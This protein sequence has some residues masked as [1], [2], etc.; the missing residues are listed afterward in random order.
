M[1]PS[2]AP[3]QY[4]ERSRW[5]ARPSGGRATARG[6]AMEREASKSESDNASTSFVGWVSDLAR[7]HTTALAR[8]ARSEG[9]TAD[10]A[11][12]AVQEA[13]QTFLGLPQARTLV[14]D[15]DDSRALLSVVV[16]NA[17][18]NLRRRHHRARPHVALDE[19]VERAEESPSVEDLLVRAE[20]H[21]RLLGC[22]SRLGDVQ[23]RVVTMRMLEELSG[24]EVAGALD[25]RP[26]HVAVL[27]HRAKRE[28]L[29]CMAG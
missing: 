10:D 7:D 21:V 13:F 8:L 11:L 14:G 2:A 4:P 26:G 9:L 17:A 23:R 12:D 22:V 20:E 27:L 28:L 6:G 1:L 15:P 18:R 16:R 5:P 29:H 19:V 25:L 24:G 3:A